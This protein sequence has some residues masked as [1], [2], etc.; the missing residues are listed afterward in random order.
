MK[1]HPT[2]RQRYVTARHTG[3]IVIDAKGPSD[4][5][6]IDIVPVLAQ[7]SRPGIKQLLFT[8]TPDKQWGTDAWLEGARNPELD[9]LGNRKQTT[10]QRAKRIHIDLDSDDKLNR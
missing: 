3:D 9:N 10:R 4:S 6:N 1:I 2:T 5:Q 8:P 7:N